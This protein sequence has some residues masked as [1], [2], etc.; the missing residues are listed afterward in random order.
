MSYIHTSHCTEDPFADLGRAVRDYMAHYE[1]TPLLKDPAYTEKR[2]AQEAS[3]T[4]GLVPEH[5]VDDSGS[6]DAI[7]YSAFDHRYFL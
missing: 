4:E 7:D 5:A 2:D 6:D 1:G 3:V